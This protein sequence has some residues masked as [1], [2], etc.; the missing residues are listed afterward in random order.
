MSV[1]QNQPREAAERAA[2]MKERFR[3]GYLSRWQN[4]R[5]WVGWKTETDEDD[6]PHKVPYNPGQPKYRASIRRPETWGTLA[7]TLAAYGSGNFDLEGIGFM[8]TPPF[9]FVDKDKSYDRTT[10]TITDPKAEEISV[11]LNA[12]LEASPRAGLH[13]YFE[14]IMPGRNLHTEDIELY[15]NWFTTITTDHIEGTPTDIL[16]RQNELNE[17]Y[18]RFAP[19]PHQ[20]DQIV[21]SRGTGLHSHIAPRL[22]SLPKEAENDAELQR[23]LRGDTSKEQGDE[24]LAD[25][26]LLMKLLHWTGDDVDLSRQVYLA[27]PL[28]QRRK[29]RKRVGPTTYV[30]MTIRNIQKKRRNRPMDR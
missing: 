16:P 21:Y 1:E 22:T 26:N 8:V 9:A 30:D 5:Q 17:L 14:G 25:W 10:R 7:Q 18:R 13:W 29:A 19:T 6:R 12:A 24:S 2:E 20:E 23:L 3:R 11:L 28:G 15:T 4:L 27:S